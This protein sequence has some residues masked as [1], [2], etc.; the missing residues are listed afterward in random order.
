MVLFEA[1]IHFNAQPTLQ[2]TGFIYT[3]N[4]NG[5]WTVTN[6]TSVDTFNW[7]VF[8]QYPTQIKIVKGDTLTTL[9]R[10][11]WGL[12]L[13]S[14]IWEGACNV[15]DFTYAWT[16]NPDLRVFSFP[17]ISSGTLFY[18]AWKG[19]SSLETFDE[20]HIPLATDI[21]E[22]FIGC[23]SLKCIKGLTFP[24][25]TYSANAFEGCD[26]LVQP[27]PSG[28][29]VRDGDDA[30]VGTWTNPN[31]CKAPIML[32][33]LVTTTADP[34]PATSIGDL[35]TVDNGDGT[36][37]IQSYGYVSHF[38]DINSKN[39]VTK[40]D[41]IKG[42][43]LDS[44]SQTFYQLINM[45]E[46]KWKGPTKFT[47]AYEAW[48][49]CKSLTSFPAIDTSSCTSFNGTWFWCDSLTTFPVID[50]SKASHKLR[51]TWGGCYSLKTF[52][53]LDYKNSA[54]DGLE[55]TWYGC[56]A[57]TCI[58]ALDTSTLTYS[59]NP[60]SD[61]TSL[62]SP[63]P[64]GL[65]RGESFGE[66]KDFIIGKKYMPGTP[67]TPVKDYKEAIRTTKILD[68]TQSGGVSVP[69]VI[70]DII[71]EASGEAYSWSGTEWV[72]YPPQ[73]GFEIITWSD[74]VDK[75]DRKVGDRYDITTAE[76]VLGIIYGEIEL[77]SSS[78]F[79][80]AEK[81]VIYIIEIK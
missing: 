29:P 32:D 14:F 80:F 47:D 75:L 37:S 11:F 2:G 21:E 44:I 33:V 65:Y 13:R 15:T 58:A 64:D 3:D 49:E 8:L 56:S 73:P 71:T 7:A 41:V 18:Q 72:V 57:L 81:S 53:E 24:V 9:N 17:N 60:F 45:V 31:E 52:P 4:G 39:S 59:W 48:R 68:S 66:E 28:T 63:P 10:A 30:T 40:I 74:L 26:S 12:K 5:T 35:F 77:T 27:P 6:E 20:L 54:L 42:E 1:L 55:S 70:G 76:P 50:I 46:F 61:C 38:K 69:A 36:W 67:C 19:C 25:T 23:S 62:I 78:R 34:L 51:Y 22:M 79:E 43:S 16:N